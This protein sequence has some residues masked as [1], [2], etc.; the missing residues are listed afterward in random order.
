MDMRV[1]GYENQVRLFLVLLVLF[2]VASGVV[3]LNVLYRSRALLLEEAESRI[4]SASNA[5]QREMKEV[6]LPEQVLAASRG[7]DAAALSRVG[8][9][10]RDLARAYSI[11]S[12][13]VL[14]LQGGILA[15]TQPWRVGVVDP[16]AAQVAESSG[17]MLFAGGAV[18][19]EPSPG[20]DEDATDGEDGDYGADR[21][22]VLVFMGLRGGPKGELEGGMQAGAAAPQL[23]LKTAHE[24]IGVRT[25]ARQIR[26]LSWTQA[27]AGLVVLALMFLFVRWVLR[28]YRALR[29][30]AARIEARDTVAGAG[31]SDASHGA[32]GSKGMHV[33]DDPDDLISSFR[34]VID[35]LKEQERELERMRM[36]A[37]PSETTGG[38]SSLSERMLNGL[39]SG[40][41]IV[42]AEGRITQLNPAGE[43]ILGRNRADVVGRDYAEVF[44]L[45]PELLRILKDGVEAGRAHSREVVAYQTA[46][47]RGPA[48]AHLG[49]TI[50][51]L[52]GAV[53]RSSGAFCLFSDLTEIRGLQ[54]R[55]RLKENLAG[56]GTLSAGIAH[57]FRNS[58]AT[59]LG[60]S[61]LITRTGE[62]EHAASIAREVESIGRIVDEFLRYA[63]PAAIQATDWNPE[64]VLTEVARETARDLGRPGVTITVNGEWPRAIRADEGLLRQAFANLL[65]NAL[66]AIPGEAGTVTVTGS[67]D[68]NGEV[69]RIEVADSGPGIPTEVLDRL[70]TPFVTTKQSGTGLGL[71][72]VQKAIVCHDGAITASNVDG[73]G[74][75]FAI[76]LPT[77]SRGLPD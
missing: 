67:V 74:A 44:A 65:R 23:L 66:E 29:E 38:V 58:L 72:L 12:I 14:D 28:P 9:K 6:G 76:T 34:G 26:L 55:V 7:S 50:S 25:V 56:L 4:T 17:G 31:D 39:T 73:G 57:E 64:A 60:Y 16:L 62:S 71:A 42:G 53:G 18:I 11:G 48:P 59:I 68:D 40:V 1:Q 3:G 63:R 51:S 20:P 41:M 37:D 35:K 22:E 15:A 46:S 36:A 24:V 8:A 2:L 69:L 52:P 45:S 13:E 19:R 30:T 10:L 21:G 5:V 27:I 43:S 77:Q 75:C 32:A 47:D 49:V 70:F 54:E 33:S 61:R